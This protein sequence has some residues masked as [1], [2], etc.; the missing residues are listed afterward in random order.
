MKYTILVAYDEDRVIGNKGEIPWRLPGDLQHFKETT[1]GGV[2]VMGRKTFES[3]GKP[4]PGRLNL[5]LT[6]G[7][8]KYLNY[9]A[10]EGLVWISDIKEHPPLYADGRDVFIIG[11][12][13]IYKL[14]LDQGLVGRIIATIVKGKHEGDAFFPPYDWVNYSMN[15]IKEHNDFNIWEYKP[16]SSQQINFPSQKDC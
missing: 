11:G 3:I 16:W 15:R 4:L 6:R 1:M 10:P 14:A 9:D 2:L 12:E 7:E 5:V 8:T 13:E